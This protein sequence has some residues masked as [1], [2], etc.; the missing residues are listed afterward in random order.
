MCQKSSI[1]DNEYQDPQS[2]DFEALRA[3]IERYGDRILVLRLFGGEPLFYSEFEKVLDLLHRKKIAYTIGTNGILLTRPIIEKITGKCAWISISIDSADDENYAR[4]RKGGELETLRENLRLLR[5]R[6]AL[7]GT[8]YPIVNGNSTVFM[9]NLNDVEQLIHFCKT[10]DIES[11]SLSSGRLYN[12]PLVTDKDLIQNSKA[13]A[14]RAIDRAR[15]LASSLDFNLRVRMRS[16]YLQPRTD[17]DR[18][19]DAQKR[20]PGLYFEMTIQPDFEAVTGFEGYRRMGTIVDNNLGSVWNGNEGR[21]TSE[22][23]SRSK[24]NYASSHKLTS[25][26]S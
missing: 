18:E 8:P 13:E 16:L 14:R 3:F 9:Y 15:A 1:D 20:S 6:K 2:M 11:L 19:R 23:G 22:R 12:T 17:A 25:L 7:K 24:T 4:I 10:F 5:D 21:Y 26:K